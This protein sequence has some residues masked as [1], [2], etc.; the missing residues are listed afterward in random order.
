MTWPASGSAMM[1][2]A[3]V[4]ITIDHPGSTAAASKMGKTAAMMPP[5]KGTNR[6]KPAK[7]PHSTALGTPMSQADANDAA[8]ARIEGGLSEK[9][10]TETLC[11]IIQGRRA[12]LQIGGAGQA[13][14]TIAQILPL[15]KQEH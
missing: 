11:G 1:N 9:K 8:E 5:T 13:Q 6:I 15:Q 10:S 2:N 7:I 14:E 12:A 3:A 4:A